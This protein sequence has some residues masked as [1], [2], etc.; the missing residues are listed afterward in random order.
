MWEEGT[1]GEEGK[2]ETVLVSKRIIPQLQIC[3]FPLVNARLFLLKHPHIFFHGAFFQTLMKAVKG[4]GRSGHGRANRHGDAG[5]QGNSQSRPNVSFLLT[6]E[7][8]E[9]CSLPSLPAYFCC[10]GLTVVSGRV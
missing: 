10:S 7:R 8:D 3:L 2:A 6:S 4:N 9:G 1:G 5:C